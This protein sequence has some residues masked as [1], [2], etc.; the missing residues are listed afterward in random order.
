MDFTHTDENGLADQLTESVAFT[1]GSS[2][3]GLYNAVK[4][5]G[6]TS[7][8]SP[9]DTEWAIGSLDSYNTLTYGPCPLEA[10]NRPPNYI[11][12]TIVVHL[13]SDDIYLSLTLT[14]W[15]A[16]GGSGDHT[17][18]YTRTT[19]GAVAPPTPTV[20]ITN[21]P[22]GTVFRA[23][24][25]V[26]IG[27]DASV[28]S[29]T[30]TNVQFLINGGSAGSVQASPFGFTANN[31]AA[32]AYALTAVATAAGVAATSTVVNIIVDTP[33]VV[34][35]TNPLNNATL[36]AP[37]NATIRASA[38]DSD[39]SVTNVQFL[40]GTTILTNVGSAPFSGTTNNLATGSYTL[41]AI[42]SDNY[43]FK[44]TNVISIAVVTPVAVSLVSPAKSSS[45]N[46]QFSY[47]A[48]VGLSYVIQRSTNLASANWI[49][50]VTNT[51]A[52]NPVVFLDVNATNSPNYYR[53]GR[54]PNP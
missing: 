29:G 16:G 40:V 46:F 51:A 5:S 1:R 13:I 2:G 39:G 17:F 21:P 33:P 6:A 54:L 14:D 34:T 38:S 26:K 36:S 27:A 45:T 8:I 4:E 24:A 43:G 19:A 12:T 32:G 47:A 9:Q 23:P 7:G 11:Q 53:V 35:I 44:N 31:L 20:T 18:S 52:S 10:G 48:N 25:N 50:L 37:A 15:G 22:S 30:V 42:A 49:P 41:T 3:G 28:S